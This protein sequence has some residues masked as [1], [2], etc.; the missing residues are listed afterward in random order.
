MDGN[1]S[2]EGLTA[3]LE[4]MKHAGIGGVIV[5]EVNV[6]VPRGRSSS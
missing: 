6:G 5:M 2:R 1:L 4:A 3:D